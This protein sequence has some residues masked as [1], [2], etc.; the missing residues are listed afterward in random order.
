MANTKDLDRKARR[1]SKRQT[2]AR[3]KKEYEALSLLQ[4]KKLRKFE[5]SFRQ[6]MVE[7]E[8]EKQ[9]QAKAAEG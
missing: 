6:F 2:R 1:K 3:N 8:K 4:K 7:Q 9:E 5:G